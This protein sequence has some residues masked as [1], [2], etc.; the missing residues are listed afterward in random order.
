M[1]EKLKEIREYEGLTQKEVAKYLGVKRATYAGWECGK[2]IIPLRKLNEFANLFHVS[3]DYIV[4]TSPNIV[5][6]K[7]INDID[8]MKVANNIKDVRIKNHLTQNEFAKSINTSQANIHKYETG[9]SLIT[10]TYALEFSKQYNYSLD[11][12]IGKK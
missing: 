8:K 6:V 11:K 10:T 9:K 3:L 4:G 2:D 5:F 12:L 7:N 1:F